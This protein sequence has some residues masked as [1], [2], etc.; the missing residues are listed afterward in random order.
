LA[1]LWICGNRYLCRRPAEKERR[2][3]SEPVHTKFPKFVQQTNSRSAKSV[4]LRK[5]SGQ[6]SNEKENRSKKAI[7]G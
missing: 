6:T 7:G 4:A 3:L 5:I 2:R 1:A